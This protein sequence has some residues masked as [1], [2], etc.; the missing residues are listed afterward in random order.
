MKR[1]IVFAGVNGAGKTTLYQTNPEMQKLPRVNLDEI[2]RE[3]GNWENMTD[4]SLAARK[5]I[6]L[7]NEFLSEG[8]SFNQ[9]T[10]LCGK[11]ILNTIRRAKRLHY[12]VEIYFVGLETPDLA[13]QRVLQRMQAGG[14]GVPEEDIERRYYESIKNLAMIM[15]ICDHVELYDNS[16]SF[17]Q[18][19]T[20]ELGRCVDKDN[21]TPGWC[22]PLIN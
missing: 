16:E 12:R 7:I 6:S 3:K 8:V 14:H 10:T 17:R 19:A 22:E 2:V 20:I 11:S 18:I 13:K 21:N 1:Y 4:V 5:A 9:E 15:P